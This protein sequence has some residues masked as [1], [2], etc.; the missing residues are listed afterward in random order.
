MNRREFLS[1]G[2]LGGGASLALGS[3][4]AQ[5][6]VRTYELSIEPV[7]VEMIDGTVVYMLLFFGGPPGVRVPRPVLRVT[8]GEPVV[9]RVTN[10]APE[11]HRFQIPG[12]PGASMTNIG[13]GQRREIRFTAPIGGSY[14]Y[15]DPLKAPLYRVVGLHGAFVSAPRAG[16]TPAGSPTPYSRISHTA[17]MQA[18]FDALGSH[19]RFAGDKWN[20]LDPEREKIWLVSQVDPELNRRVEQ[21]LAVDP[22]TIAASFKPR[23]FTINGRSGFD[24]EEDPTV[25]I[26]GYIGQPTLIRTLNAGLATHALHIHG[27]HVFALSGQST[28]GVVNVRPNIYER[29]TWMLA[30]LERRDV[31]L[32]I[33]IPPNLPREVWPPRQER[34]P[35]RYVMH[36]HTEMSQTAGGGNYPQGIVTHW[37]LL[38]PQRPA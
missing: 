17:A 5:T 32:P 15:L 23:Y 13:P 12:A 3:A 8:E 31:L 36:C 26:S 25:R 21:R 27:N 7:D 24:L 2:A 9:I 19:P 33:E 14:L 4:S 35:L 30:P 22:A 10:N 6:A 16:A 11:E 38:G 34:F 29:D 1:Y 37:E 18:V 20:P 28:S